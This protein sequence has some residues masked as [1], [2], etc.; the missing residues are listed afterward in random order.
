MLTAIGSTINQYKHRR[1]FRLPALP[2]LRSPLTASTAST[3]YRAPIRASTQA[4]P[5]RAQFTC[6][7]RSMVRLGVRPEHWQGLRRHE[8]IFDLDVFADTLSGDMLFALVLAYYLGFDVAITLVTS[9]ASRVVLGSTL[10]IVATPSAASPTARPAATSRSSCAPT[11]TYFRPCL[12][13]HRP[14]SRLRRVRRIS[15]HRLLHRKL[16]PSRL[17]T[18]N[19]CSRSG[20]V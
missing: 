18:L 11:W 16:H 4:S 17:F 6:T 13:S 9:L 8:R 1:P 19:V 10:R 12:Q 7:V 20:R 15:R 14:R 3:R 2:P 5:D